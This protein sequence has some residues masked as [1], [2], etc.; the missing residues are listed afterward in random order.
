M[1]FHHLIPSVTALLLLIGPAVPGS[2]AQVLIEPLAAETIPVEPTA[3]ARPFWGVAMG[4]RFAKIPFDASDSTVTDVFPL[5]YYEGERVFLR[6]LEGGLKLVD[7]DNFGL[8]LIGRYR[9]FDIPR[10]QQNEDR[11]DALDMGPQFV[12]P[13]TENTRAEVELLTD[14]DGNTHA[15][16]RLHGE[17]NGRRWHLSPQVEIRAKS[18]EFNSAYYGLGIADVSAGVDARARL[19]ARYQLYRNLHLVGSTEFGVLDPQA[20]RSPFVEDTW[21]WEWYVGFGVFSDAPVVERAAP[22][23]ARPYWR[24][25]QGWGSDATIAE[26][27]TG[28]NATQPVDVRMTSLFYGHPLSDTVLAAPSRSSSPLASCTTGLPPI[29][30]PPPNTCSR[31]SSTTPFTCPGACASA[32]PRASPTW[33]PA[34]TTKSRTSSAA[35]TAAAAFSTFSISAPT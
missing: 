29:K 28:Q 27:M 7:H 1:R 2:R 33:T 4:L 19:R 14:V 5:F 8:N 13:L 6:G 34:P 35:T 24:L 31:S 3:A 21:E 22:L 16:L 25:S 26:I 12:L 9:F 15:N 23:E 10:E 32:S 30:T 17:F 11:G 20:R 18:A